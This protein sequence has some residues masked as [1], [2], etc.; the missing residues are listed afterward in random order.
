MEPESDAPVRRI[1]S[2]EQ[3]SVGAESLERSAMQFSRAQQMAQLG[4]W[5]WEIA[6]GRMLWSEE[7]FRILGLDPA[8]TLPTF[9]AFLDAIHSDDRPAMERRIEEALH[10]PGCL[11][12]E[13]RTADS[14]RPAR[15]IHCRA[16]VFIDDDD[17]PVRMIGT[18][19]DVTELRRSSRQLKTQ[20]EQLQQ[21]AEASVAIY[22]AEGLE[23]TLEAATSHA[24]RIVGASRARGSLAQRDRPGESLVHLSHSGSLDPAARRLLAAVEPLH[25][26]VRLARG[27]VD[28]HDLLSTLP[29]EERVLARGGWMVVPLSDILGGA[30]GAIQLFEKHY[31][32]FSENDE[33]LVMQVAQVT[34][35]ALQKSRLFDDLLLS[36][37]RY[38]RLFDAHLSGD[39]V[40]S[41]DGVFVDVNLTMARIL[42]RDSIEALK[43][44]DARAVYSNPAE[45]ERIVA[46]IREQRRAFQQETELA[47]ADGSTLFAIV[48][49]VGVFDRQGEMVELQGCLFDVTEWKAAEAA[50]R[51]SQQQLLQS[52]KMEAVGQLAGGIAHDFNNMLTAIKGFADLLEEEIPPTPD[53]HAH[54]TEIRKA[55]DRSAR[56]TRQLLAYSRKQILQPEV[57][58]LNGVVSGMEDMLRRLIGEHIEYLCLL[59][60]EAG[61][62]HADPGQLQQVLMNLVLNA[63]DAMA[64]G[65]EL[66]VQTSTKRINAPTDLGDFILPADDYAVLTVTDSGRGIPKAVLPRIFEPFFTTKAVGLGSGLGLSTVYG[67]V[68][69]SGGYIQASSGVEGGATFTLLLPRTRTEIESTAAG[70]PLPATGE[71]HGKGRVLVV[72][73]E[74]VLRAL[75]AKVLRRNGFEVIEA[76][77]GLDALQKAAAVD[78]DIDILVT[79]VVMPKIGGEQLAASLLER[80]PTLPIVFMSGYAEEVIARQ[81]LLITNSVFLE[82]PFPPHLLVRAVREVCGMELSA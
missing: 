2:S 23:E 5:E 70:S 16:E 34:S 66:I 10:T 47:R 12:L 42:G 46:R 41:A 8:T 55:A 72:E 7:M 56:L 78:Y 11:E 81:G 18:A 31:G 28:R 33:S 35:L 82:K 62:V 36:E 69:Q 40:L 17:K 51:E 75:A 24:L 14:G 53:A 30:S 29:E 1:E 74:T 77:D 49:L 27:E 57:L 64:D 67:I 21:L 9:D 13:Y 48:N 4:S 44:V 54:L 20:I 22:A 80:R 6:T 38:R 15:S 68:K 58:E 63:R 79:D 76:E 73:D 37:E 52:Q 25:H 43:G 61:R 39:F 60:P 45:L 59:D 65:G 19:H 3:P 71:I 32:D 50:L 26:P